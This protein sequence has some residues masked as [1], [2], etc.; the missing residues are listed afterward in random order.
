MGV[1]H[2]LLEQHRDFGDDGVDRKQAAT[3]AAVALFKAFKAAA[4][5]KQGGFPATAGSEY[6]YDFSVF[7]R[8]LQPLKHRPLSQANRS[9]EQFK[10]HVGSSRHVRAR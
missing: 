9:I 8:E 6:R 4:C 3:E 1:Q 10:H 7:D 5:S 2:G